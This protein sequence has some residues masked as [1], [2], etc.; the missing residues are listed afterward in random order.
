MGSELNKVYD[1]MLTCGLLKT[2]HR[3]IEILYDYHLI[4]D[5]NKIFKRF[6]AE[7]IQFLTK[8]LPEL[9]HALIQGLRTS[10]FVCP[11]HFKKLKGTKLPM[12]YHQVFLRIF[13]SSG[14]LRL[15][16]DVQAI[17]HLVQ[18]FF[19]FYKQ[20]IPYTKEQK[21]RM[22]TKYIEIDRELSSLFLLEDD[23]VLNKAEC[24]ITEL[25]KDFDPMDIVP[26]SSNGALATGDVGVD[27]IVPKRKY[28]NLH[29]VYPY[30]DYMYAN[31]LHV[32][33]LLRNENFRHYYKNLEVHKYATSK[34]LFVPKD[35]RGPRTICMEPAE[36]Q[37]MQQGLSRKIVKHLEKHT[38]NQINF[39]KQSYNQMAALN[40]SLEGDI[41]T[42]DF[43][44]ASDRVS[45][46][47]VER[48]FRGVPRLLECLVACR[49]SH[50]ELPNGEIIKIKK[51]AP[52]GSSLCFPVMATVIYAITK[53]LNPSLPVLVYGDDLIVENASD[54]THL[55]STFNKYGLKINHSK[56]F[57]TGIFRESCGYDAVLGELITPI[58]LKETL[59]CTPDPLSFASIV[60]ASNAFYKKGFWLVANYLRHYL[61]HNVK[62]IIPTSSV[63]ESV[64]GLSFCFVTDVN[65]TLGYRLRFEPAYKNFTETK[66]DLGF[67][68]MQRH[69]LHLDV[70][71]THTYHID[72]FVYAEGLKVPDGATDDTIP[73]DFVVRCKDK[74]AFLRFRWESMSSIIKNDKILSW[75]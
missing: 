68:V 6:T 26:K 63:L 18:F 24:I 5:W 42:Y 48:L 8:T 23:Y 1:P 44:A 56:S 41:A 35:S 72:D 14:R 21:E 20:E 75:K 39:K 46:L 54:Y 49:S 13:D 37:F 38:H 25:F 47:L 19:C 55:E 32:S 70:P 4:K 50:V 36:M 45:L 60:D 66:K 59:K 2:L 73:S 17:E 74:P 71:T 67:P 62:Y 65:S 53:A 51:F 34:L 33:T 29:R 15:L 11:T 61:Q 9:G 52:M 12:M 7:K 31:I 3:E 69:A 16:P 43:S 28:M 58:K 57:A 64:G 27:K 10:T 22:L 40:G 30:Y